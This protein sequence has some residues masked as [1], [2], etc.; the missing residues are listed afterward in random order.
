ML[1]NNSH[2]RAE[3]VIAV[4]LWRRQN[5]VFQFLQNVLKL[6][7]Y[8]NN[9]FYNFFFGLLLLLFSLIV[10]FV[11]HYVH[12]LR[13]AFT[14]LYENTFFILNEIN[15]KNILKIVVIKNSLKLIIIY[16]NIW[17]CSSNV[18]FGFIF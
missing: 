7:V 5:V 12:N 11:V 4:I 18:Y 1:E 16:E 8:M 10:Y 3:E 17:Y 15:E 13:I 2:A 6:F 9:N 14:V